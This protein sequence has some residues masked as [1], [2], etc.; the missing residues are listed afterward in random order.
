M[1][2]VR[3]SSGGETLRSKC[4][5]ERHCQQHNISAAADTLPAAQLQVQVHHFTQIPS[6]LQMPME[7]EI[8]ASSESFFFNQLICSFLTTYSNGINYLSHLK[9]S[10]RSRIQHRG[11]LKY[12]CEWSS[13]SADLWHWP[14]T[15]VL[16]WGRRLHFI[17]YNKDP[18]T[19]VFIFWYHM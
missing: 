6:G 3:S 1:S 18:K 2:D 14:R 15:L 5:W 7:V 13:V 4:V 8:S 19:Q 12:Q 10:V 16:N 11:F 17:P 9:S